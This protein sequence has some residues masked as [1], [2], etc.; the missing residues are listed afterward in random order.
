MKPLNNYIAIKD[1]DGKDIKTQ[2][3]I[4][5]ASE[6]DERDEYHTGIVDEVSDTITQD[7]KKG[8]NILYK[9]YRN[10]TFEEREF[11]LTDDVIAKL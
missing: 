10:V 6:A 11:I 9:H 7:I 3:G 4:I 5:I 8:D 1:V 2:G